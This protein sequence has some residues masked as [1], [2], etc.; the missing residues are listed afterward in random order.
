MLSRKEDGRVAKLKRKRYTAKDIT[1]EQAYNLYEEEKSRY[2]VSEKTLFNYRYAFT[3]WNKVF[4]LGEDASIEAATAYSYDEFVD[5]LR[6]TNIKPESINTYVRNIN[7][8]FHWLEAGNFIQGR[9]RG[10]VLKVEDT[11]PK[12]VEDQEVEKLLGEYDRN[13]FTESRCYTIICL[14]LATGIRVGSAAELL[15]SDWDRKEGILTLRKT[16][17]RRQQVIYLPASAQ[18]VL[19]RYYFDY[20]HDTNI[21]YLF[22]NYM[23]DK[24]SVIGLE[25]AH[26]KFCE[27]RGVKNNHLHSLRHAFSYYYIR[28]GGDLYRLQKMLNHTSV[29]STMR[30]GRLFDSDIAND[31]EKNILNDFIGTHRITKRKH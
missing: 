13:D 5:A 10:I 18:E 7:H 27:K 20:L 25:K 17:T 3:K 24:I 22:P 15:I 26:R 2:N 9:R 4:E 29:R 19:D 31:F 28:N 14:M 16:K 8:F 23:G 6:A 30:Y 21:K 12:F 11:L 1:W